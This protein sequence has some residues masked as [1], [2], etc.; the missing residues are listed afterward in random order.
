MI[1]GSARLDRERLRIEEERQEAERLETERQ[2][3]AMQE[4]E[5]LQEDRE[6][7]RLARLQATWDAAI[8][9]TK[10]KREATE[11][12]EAREAYDSEMRRREEQ[13]IKKKG[14]QED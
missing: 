11:P 3:A 7:E 14:E 8:R 10:R 5:R 9:E 4:A 1:G 13:K 6:Q 12:E 2:Y